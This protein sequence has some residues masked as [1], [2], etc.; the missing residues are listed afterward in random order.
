M[1][2]VLSFFML[3]ALPVLQLWLKTPQLLSSVLF[4]HSTSSFGGGLTSIF[5]SYLPSCSETASER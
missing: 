1:R 4:W 5:T 3:C 2:T